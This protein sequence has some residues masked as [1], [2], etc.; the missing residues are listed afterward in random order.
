MSLAEARKRRDDAR[1]LLADD[2]D[3][4]PARHQERDACLIAASNTFELVAR[5][6]LQKEGR[7]RSP[8]TQDKVLGWLEHDGFQYIGKRAVSELKPRDVLLMVQKARTR[9]PLSAIGLPATRVSTSTS[10]Q[11][12]PRGSIKSS[13]GSRP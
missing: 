6:W 1:V 12:R 9:R 3:P 8:S 13:A 10:R 7:R 4:A 5:L 2:I 11:R